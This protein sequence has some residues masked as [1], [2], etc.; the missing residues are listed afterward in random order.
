MPTGHV[1]I[2]SAGMG[3]GHDRVAYQLARR[4]AAARIEAEVMDVLDLLPLRL[5][6]GLRRWYRWTMRHA[7]WV[8]AAIYRVFLASRWAPAASPLTTLIA[9]RLER[10]IRRRTPTAL[11]ST[12]H[13]AAQAAGRLR[14]EGRLPVPSVVV[15]TD[16]AVHR[17]W[18][19]PGNDAYLSPTPATARRIR[20]ATGRPAL[21]HAPL[22]APEFHPGPARVR[23][24]L[25]LVSTGAWGVGQ[26]ERTVR[27]LAR[28][29]RYVPVVL[30]GRNERL[31]RR[32]H[33][34][35][36]CVPLGWREDAA[37]LMAA[38]YALIDNTSGLTC[39]EAL[40]AG[41]PVISY[42]PIPGHGRDGARAMAQAGLSVH[43][44]GAGG[45]LDALDRLRTP[46]G[47]E[48]QAARA[49]AL[50]EHPPA[51]DL[52]RNLLP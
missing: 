2:L 50:F 33:R 34:V 3:A 6:A 37:D 49:R 43:A 17:L 41:L 10:L 52:L 46:G 18:L 14:A 31:R 51:E 40:A 22:V 38:A 39:K 35:G 7:P 23:G 1:L 44:R 9:A 48:R 16:F 25:V 36:G 24:E 15:V 21:C 30:C 5:G 19:H 4:L 12:F 29:G 27:V 42:R 32:L 26:A 11:V 47:R 45:L 13:V 28:S 20:A 8:Y